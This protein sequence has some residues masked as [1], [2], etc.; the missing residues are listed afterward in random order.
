MSYPSSRYGSSTVMFI[1]HLAMFW[2]GTWLGAEE[3][4]K[5]DKQ[6]YYYLILFQ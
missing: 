6:E 2:A 1:C 4:Q 3:P 5:C